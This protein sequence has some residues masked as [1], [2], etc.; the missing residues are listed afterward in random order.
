MKQIAM[1][2]T[3]LNAMVRE[4]QAQ[5]LETAAELKVDGLYGEPLHAWLH[6]RAAFVRRSSTEWIKEPTWQ[7]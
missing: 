6:A 2:V 1:K 7:P 3:E 4:A 5:A